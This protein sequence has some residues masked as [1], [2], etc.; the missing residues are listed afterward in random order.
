LSLILPPTAE[1]DAVSG[2]LIYLDWLSALLSLILSILPSELGTIYFCG[3]VLS[4]L[5]A[6]TLIE[7]A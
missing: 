4:M 1:L 7:A 3:D 2:T 5:A 6:D